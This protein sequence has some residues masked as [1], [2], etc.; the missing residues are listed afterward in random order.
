MLTCF[1]LSL[2][3]WDSV[4]VFLFPF[5]KPLPSLGLSLDFNVLYKKLLNVNFIFKSGPIKTSSIHTVLVA[6]LLREVTEESAGSQFVLCFGEGGKENGDWRPRTLSYL[7]NVPVLRV[8]NT[9]LHLNS[10]TR[11]S[12]CYFYFTHEKTDLT[13]TDL[14][15]CDKPVIIALGLK[16][17]FDWLSQAFASGPPRKSPHF[18]IC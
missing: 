3:C 7:P 1:V 4:F 2:P 12:C 9:L 6:F 10:P 14:T 18:L 15:G 17:S 11:I 13:L 5:L 16:S 8:F